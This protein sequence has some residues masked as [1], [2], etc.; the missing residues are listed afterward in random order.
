MRHETRDMGFNN[1]VQNGVLE[2]H[3]HRL[4]RFFHSNLSGSSLRTESP[5]LQNNGR[6]GW[7][8]RVC[9]VTHGVLEVKKHRAAHKLSLEVPA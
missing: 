6:G 2:T 3:Q 5:P 8:V 4:H 9:H 7:G 1:T